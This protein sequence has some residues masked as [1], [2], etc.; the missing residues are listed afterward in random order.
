[1]SIAGGFH[2]AIERGRE[3]KCQCVQIFVKNNNQWRASEIQEQAVEQFHAAVSEHAIK[4]LIAHSSYLINLASPDA[5][6]RRKS[7]DALVVELHRAERLRIPYVVLHP[8]AYTNGSEDAGL[9]LIVR[10][11][12]E[13]QRQTRAL[14]AM[15]LLENTAGQGTCLGWRFE[16]LAALLDGV[17]APERVGVC[18]DTCHAFAA[19]YALATEYDYRQTMRQLH[20]LVGLDR[21][22]AIH[23]NDS[24][25]EL[26]ARVDRHE[27]I[28]RGRIGVQAFAHLLS[29]DRLRSVPMYLETPKGDDPK[30]GQSWDA[31]NLRRLRRLAAGGRREAGGRRPEAGG[32][33]REA[34]AILD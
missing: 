12:D 26:G 16:H 14:R 25:R 22:K 30:S 20:Q 7:V 1:M 28:G 6:L 29:D 33:R 31:I 19:G 5:A 17:Q 23:V 13:V 11:L 8:G 18:F 10:G 2:R 4:H 9:R 32:G 21:I 24:K 27:H 3:V 15:C 34:G